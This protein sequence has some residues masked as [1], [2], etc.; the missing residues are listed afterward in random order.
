MGTVQLDVLGGTPTTLQDDVKTGLMVSTAV[1]APCATIATSNLTLLGIEDLGGVTGEEG[2]RVLVIS[3]TD[4]AENGIYDMSAAA[5]Q[6]SADARFNG[7]LVDGTQVRVVGG[8][9]PGLYELTSDDPITLDIDDQTWTLTGGSNT[10][11][12]GQPFSLEFVVCDPSTGLPISGA[13]FATGDVTV[14]KDGGSFVNTTNLPAVS[15]YQCTLGLTA[16]EMDA[17]TVTV[18]IIDQTV[19]AAWLNLIATIVTV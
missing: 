4:A 2:Q 17:S 6:R 10:L 1:K 13:S 15:G 12:V 5:W 11:V 16:S 9:A 14:S 8:A 7:Q 18:K 3:Q 19:P